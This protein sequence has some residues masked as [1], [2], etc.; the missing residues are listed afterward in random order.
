MT[1]Y[2]LPEHSK[3]VPM[4]YCSD[5][6]RLETSTY[7]VTLNKPIKIEKRETYIPNTPFDGVYTF[8]S[9]INECVGFL[10]MT[11]DLITIRYRL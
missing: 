2:I 7:K 8:P 1:H 3:V 5:M 4:Y 10:Y 11:N 9:P 6:M